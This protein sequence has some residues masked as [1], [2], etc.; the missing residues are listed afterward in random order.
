[1]LRKMTAD[2]VVVGAGVAG[3]SAYYGL[4]K[5]NGPPGDGT[6]SSFKPL[7]VD[8][9]GPMSLTSARGTYQYRNWWP[10]EGD[11]AMMRLVSRS[12][13]IMDDVASDIDL[14]R[15]GYLFVTR[16][17]A[18]VN[19]LKAQG[20]RNEQLG[21]GAFREHHE[22]SGYNPSTSVADR[23]DGSDLIWGQDNIATLF[24][25]LKHSN[26]LAALHVRRAGSLNP[27]KLVRSMAWLPK[28]FQPFSS[29]LECRLNS[30]W[31]MIDIHACGGRISGI[32]VGL[33]NG[34]K[35]IVDT[36]ALVLAPGPMLQQTLHLLRAKDL[37]D[38]PALTVHHE[39]HAR[40]IFDDPKQI[41]TA[42]SPL[43]FHADPVGRLQ[44]MAVWTY[45]VNL[46]EPVF[47]LTRVLD[48]R[49]SA[50]A[51]EVLAATVM[52]DIAPGKG[53]D[54]STLPYASYAAALSPSRF[55][56]VAYVSS[57]SSGRQTSG[58]M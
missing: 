38:T 7:L 12:I 28:S 23:L 26:A 42:T 35:E 57:L 43:T 30:C 44:A 25:S 14:N 55:D 41:A 31:K 40:V 15:N 6:A 36:A 24:P 51:G 10:D 3:C 13:D 47:P 8:A 29:S 52:G 22:L 17:L 16:D 46:V 34:D 20:Q 50:A 49:S 48:P 21:G 1:M 45:D 54:D 27:H 56:D 5:R 9:T 53:V 37:V 19:A 39:L 18:R 32:T 11:E 33:P 58:Q 2:V 4:A